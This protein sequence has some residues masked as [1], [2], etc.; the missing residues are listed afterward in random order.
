MFKSLASVSFRATQNE[1]RTFSHVIC[2][3]TILHSLES[4]H[5]HTKL[6]AKPLIKTFHRL[7]PRFYATTL[8]H[9]PDQARTNGRLLVL[10]DHR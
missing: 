4:I 2:Q 10:Q 1:Q 3:R 9:A 7:V 6:L 5:S 8:L